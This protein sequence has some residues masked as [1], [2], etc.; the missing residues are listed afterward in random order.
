MYYRILISVAFTYL[1]L[2]ELLMLAQRLQASFEKFFGDNPFFSSHLEK[3]SVAVL[4]LTTAFQR[5]RGSKYTERLAEKDRGR[6]MAFQSLVSFLDGMAGLKIDE[7]MSVPAQQLM[8]II[9]KHNRSLHRL[10][11]TQQSAAL[12][13]LIEELS[14]PPNAKL[15]EDTKTTEYFS[16]L[17]DA[18]NDF[19]ATFSEKMD[20]EGVKGYPDARE[21]AAD[22]V[23]RLW[24]ML[25]AADAAAHD[26]PAKFEQAAKELN[27]VISEIMAPARARAT[28]R[29]NEGEVEQVEES[30]EMV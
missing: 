16:I 30:A 13:A 11:Y 8:D 10:G 27:A 15:L 17:V 14:Q 28:R 19:E 29:E 2:Q 7:A 21:S 1:S 9:N 5:A 18:H 26:E 24:V 20:D 4:R 3:L 12:K 6:D 22:I 25:T 23:Y